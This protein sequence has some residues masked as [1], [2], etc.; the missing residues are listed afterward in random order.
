MFFNT[1][2]LTFVVV[3][4]NVLVAEAQLRCAELAR[5]VC[6]RL[7]GEEGSEISIRNLVGQV[8]ESVLSNQDPALAIGKALERSGT[9]DIIFVD[10]NDPDLGKTKNSRVELGFGQQTRLTLQASLDELSFVYR[11]IWDCAF[12]MIITYLCQVV[13]RGRGASQF[14]GGF[15]TALKDDLERASLDR[16]VL[17]HCLKRLDKSRQDGSRVLLTVPLHFST[18]AHPSAWADFNQ[19]YRGV[20]PDALRYLAFLIFGLRGVSNNALVRELPKLTGAR[21]LFCALECNDPVGE[22]FENTAVHSVGIEMPQG[23]PDEARLTGFIMS[24]VRELRA[25]EVEPFVFGV[26]STS[27]MI[28]AM[29]VGVRYLEGPA[30]HPMMADPRFAVV[31]GLEDIYGN[32]LRSGLTNIKR[33]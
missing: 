23:V 33:I 22:R 21:H 32:R 2:E 26:W 10:H 16:V 15:C 9:E 19:A 7:F 29:G 6:A 18:L 30:V 28:S 31:H 1:G 17:S 25:R 14:N 20:T 4:R 13:P 27:H 11:P 3:Y 5:H 8:D 24:K 12:D